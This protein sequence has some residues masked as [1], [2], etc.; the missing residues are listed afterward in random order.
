[1]HTELALTL[2]DHLAEHPL[3]ETLWARW[4]TAL[5]R[6]GRTAEALQHYEELRTGIA[7]ELGV[8][9][10]AELRAIHTSILQG[11]IEQAQPTQSKLDVSIEIPQHLPVDLAEFSGRAAQ[12][13][14]LDA[15]LDGL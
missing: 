10:S 1:N 4:L 8:D 5:H 7:E 13:N 9:P 11:N 2:R 3:R 15:Q 14:E 12:L 6:C